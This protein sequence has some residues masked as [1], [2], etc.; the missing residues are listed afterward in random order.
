[1]GP[2]VG[3][4]EAVG[5]GRPMVEKLIPYILLM[6]IGSGDIRDQSGSC[7][8]SRQVLDDFFALANFLG[9]AFQK[10]YP[11]YHPCLTA[12]RLEKFPEDTPASPEVV[13]KLNFRPNF[14]FHDYFL[15]GTP[16]TW[17]V[18]YI[19][20]LGECLAHVKKLRA[21]HPLRAEM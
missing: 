5:V 1:V 15:W 11:F 10:L 20:S 16:P 13:Y 12:C 18:R 2:G 8:K 14:K 3:G 17:G 19:A 9:R 6:L 7:Q 21:Q 4:S